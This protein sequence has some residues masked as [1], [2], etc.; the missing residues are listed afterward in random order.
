MNSYDNGNGNLPPPS[1]DL[2]LRVVPSLVH[3]GYTLKCLDPQNHTLTKTATVNILPTF[4][5]SGRVRGTGRT[6][7]PA[8]YR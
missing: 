5:E 3:S 6:K 8:A 4:D 7:A 1:A 2:E